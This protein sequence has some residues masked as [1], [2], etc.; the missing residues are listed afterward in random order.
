MTE[1]VSLSKSS[2]VQTG[3]M[4]LEDMLG[5]FF[6]DN[7]RQHSIDMDIA[8][9]GKRLLALGWC[10]HVTYNARLG[11]IVDGHGRVLAC[12]WLSE[13]SPEWF[14]LQMRN[15][16]Q[17]S[18]L[19]TSDEERYSPLYWTNVSIIATNLD[20]VS[21]A[22]MNLGLNNEKSFG[23]DDET[24]V[25]KI[26]SSFSDD[27]LEIAGFD[28]KVK[29][30]AEAIAQMSET[31][32]QDK[33][34]FERPDATDYS[35]RDKEGDRLEMPVTVSND[36]DSDDDLDNDESDFEE[37]EEAIAPEPKAAY[38]PKVLLL[39]VPFGDWRKFNKWK[40]E[41]SI[42]KDTDAFWKGLQEAFP[43]DLSFAKAIDPDLD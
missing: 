24:K 4:P 43:D 11:K 14:D 9:L 32:F 10:E 31:E 28:R 16:K 21:H 33:Q 18:P 1:I 42:D 40:K 37:D 27:E 41:K 35:V 36:D 23:Y 6:E 2:K 15:A 13:Q 5:A 12:R 8:D 26:T 19:T 3:F 17:R 38:V 30:V 29:A 22:A 39:A 25:S 20:T 7:A 34:Y